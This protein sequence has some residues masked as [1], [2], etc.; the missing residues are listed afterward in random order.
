M[1]FT[2]VYMSDFHV[3]LEYYFKLFIFIIKEVGN[4]DIKGRLRINQNVNL[5][6]ILI[7]INIFIIVDSQK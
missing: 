3:N 7:F 5:E 1:F 2:M 4:L 6:K